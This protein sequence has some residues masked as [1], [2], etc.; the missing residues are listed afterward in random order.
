MKFPASS[1]E[2]DWQ[3]TEQFYNFGDGKGQ[4]DVDRLILLIK[5]KPRPIKELDLGDWFTERVRDTWGWPRS[6]L[7]TPA[8]VDHF[9]EPRKLKGSKIFPVIVCKRRKKTYIIDG[10]HRIVR[11]VRRKKLTYPCVYVTYREILQCA[12]PSIKKRR[13]RSPRTA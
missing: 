12:E 2:L 3:V 7:V 6:A 13:S 10:I 4:Y 8:G 11:A 5:A 9:F 1:S